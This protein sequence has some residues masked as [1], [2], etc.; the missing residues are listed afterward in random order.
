MPHPSLS[1]TEGKEA[2]CKEAGY[3]D[4]WTCTDC[5]KRFA[6]EAGT[7]EITEPEEIPLAARYIQRLGGDK[8]AHRNGKGRTE[9]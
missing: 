5:N 9:A 8:A 6:D 4:F 7:V 3:K 2:T 1:K